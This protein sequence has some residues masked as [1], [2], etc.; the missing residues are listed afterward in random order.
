MQKLLSGCMLAMMFIA[1]PVRGQDPIPEQSADL[2]QEKTTQPPTV[3]PTALAAYAKWRE[4]TLPNFARKDA[5]P[6]YAVSIVAQR[7]DE[8]TA[9]VEMVWRRR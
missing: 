4:A 7:L 3:T 8:Q 2:S 9:Q 6:H 5:T 1:V